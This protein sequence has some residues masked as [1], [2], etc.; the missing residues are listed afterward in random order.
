MCWPSSHVSLHVC[1][2][3]LCLLSIHFT[4]ISQVDKTVASFLTPF[5][6]NL[7]RSGW[8]CCSPSF[9]PAPFLSLLSSFEPCPRRAIFPSWSEVRRQGDGGRGVEWAEGALLWGS[10]SALLSGASRNC[11]SQQSMEGLVVIWAF[12]I[13]HSTQRSILWPE[14]D[15]SK[16]S[17][18]SHAFTTN[19]GMYVCICHCVKQTRSRKACCLCHVGDA[20]PLKHGCGH[21]SS[22]SYGNRPLCF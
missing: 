21:C 6:L 20:I 2:Q 8:H 5:S 3:C 14:L 7:S 1:V 12:L 9:H 19:I 22:A 17:A 13:V 16:R 18:N 15:M 4:S 10:V 11:I